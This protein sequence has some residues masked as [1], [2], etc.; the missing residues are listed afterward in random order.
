MKIFVRNRVH[1]RASLVGMPLDCQ[2]ISTAIQRPQQKRNNTC[3]QYNV[4]SV[5]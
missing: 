4:V 5:Y 3:Y 1:A 2:Y